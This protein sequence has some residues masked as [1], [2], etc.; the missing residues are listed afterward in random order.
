MSEYVNYR[1][2]LKLIH[3]KENETYGDFCKRVALT[4]PGCDE[5]L[6]SYYDT[7]KNILYMNFM[8]I[9]LLLMKM[10]IG[11]CQNNKLII[12]SLLLI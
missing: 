9:M 3:K 10:C 7:G 11:L 8:I 12:M 6:P 4:C 5:N 2:K 1:G